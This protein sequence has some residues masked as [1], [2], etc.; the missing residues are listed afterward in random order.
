M[1]SFLQ[2]VTFEVS[3]NGP[4]CRID[5]KTIAIIA[6]MMNASQIKKPKIRK[7]MIARY[8]MMLRVLFP[9]KVRAMWPPSNIPTGIRLSTVIII[10]TQPAKATGCSDIAS[11]DSV[12]GG[13]AP[14]GGNASPI[15]ENSNGAGSVRLPSGIH[16]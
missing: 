7:V 4:G 16:V 14:N 11:T 13:I 5:E 6:H 8:D 10:P 1:A 3:S 9:R 12:W 2:V 15:N